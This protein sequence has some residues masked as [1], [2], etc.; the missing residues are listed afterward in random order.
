MNPVTVRVSRRFDARPERIFDAW[1]DPATVGRWLYAT[2]DGH[3]LRVEVDPRVGGGYTIV[4]RR[5][6]GDAAHYGRYLEIDRPRRLVLTLALEPDAPGDRITV[7][8]APDGEGC[9]LTLTHEMAAENAQYADRT[10]HGWTTI[11][12]SLD[13]H[14]HTASPT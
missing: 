12:A 14:L 5:P 2:K 8:I 10:G 6:G 11:L 7:D 9:M 1:L 4:E 3:M 13:R